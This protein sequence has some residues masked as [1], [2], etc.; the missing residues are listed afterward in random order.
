MPV[1][2]VF[3]SAISY[4]KK[5][6]L[7]TINKERLNNENN[8]RSNKILKDKDVLWV[9]TVPAIWSERSKYFMLKAAKMVNNLYKSG[10][11]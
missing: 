11:E 10:I 9:I 5:H 6:L 3:S 4:L 7:D 8:I 1:L 2:V